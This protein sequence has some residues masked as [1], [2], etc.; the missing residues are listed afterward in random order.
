MSDLA[1]PWTASHQ[2]SLSFTKSRSL[3]K[4]MSIESVM[5]SNKLFP[6]HPIHFCLQSFPASGSFPISQHYASS[7]QS[8]KASAS[9]PV[10]Q[11]SIQ[12][13]FHLGL[14]GLIFLLSKGFSRAFSSTTVQN[15]NSLVLSILHGPTLTTIHDSWKKTYLWLCGP[16]SSVWCLCF[17][18]RCLGLSSL[19][20]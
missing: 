9:A 16:L 3:H 12:G 14:T 13:W 19:F 20:F 4:L 5:L 11:M 7:D 17:L 2:S 18:I 10:L 1:T 8:I 6:C 15:I